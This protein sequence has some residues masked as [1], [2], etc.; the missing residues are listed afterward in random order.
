[1]SALLRYL[2]QS[3]EGGLDAAAALGL[4]DGLHAPLHLLGSLLLSCSLLGLPPLPLSSGLL[5][6][7]ALSCRGILTF[8]SSRGFFS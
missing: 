5:L 7:P 4:A 3:A 8:S 6:T 2:K 1:M